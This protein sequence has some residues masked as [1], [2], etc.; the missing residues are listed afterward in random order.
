[1]LSASTIRTGMPKLWPTS[2]TPNAQIAP[3]PAST[4]RPHALARPVDGP[5]G[6]T[7]RGFDRPVREC[8]AALRHR[9]RDFVRSPILAARR[10]LLLPHRPLG[11]GQDVIA[12]TALPGAAAEPGA[13]PAV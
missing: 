7:E 2:G 5:G 1:M 9:R 3:A 6:G 13:D 10:R 12:E 8:R 11:R 4:S